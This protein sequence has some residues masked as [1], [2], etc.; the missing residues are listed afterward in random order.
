MA[1]P[2][3]SV[4]GCGRPVYVKSSGLC[5]SCYFKRPD[6]PACLAEGCD[7]KGQ[8]RRGLCDRC[9]QRVRKHGD[10]STVLIRLPGTRL[11]ELEA[12]ARTTTDGC[13]ILARPWPGSRPHV[14]FQGSTMLAAR[15]VWTLAHGDP[16][17]SQVLHTCNGGSGADGCISIR[18]LYLGDHA[19]NMQDKVNAGRTHDSRGS[20]NGHAK[21]NDDDVR[22]IRRR[23][24]RGRGPYDPGNASA[25][26]EEFGIGRTM[27]CEIARRTKWA[28]VA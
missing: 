7:R 21:L 2:T 4:N 3:C 1:Q 15:A 9:R 16:G 27:L 11:A 24:V 17:E 10:A 8:L 20:F 25:L 23:Y 13:V 18:H 12:A 14:L 19:K 28:H 5:R 22:E 26:A 6:G